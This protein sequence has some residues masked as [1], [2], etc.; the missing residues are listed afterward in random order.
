MVKG[1][2][3]L[4]QLTRFETVIRT[5]GG[6]NETARLVGKSASHVCNWRRFR[7]KIPAKYY[8]IIQEA[9]ADQG[10]TPA[11][12]L[13]NFAKPVKPK[14]RKVYCDFSSGNVIIVDFRRR[15]VRIAA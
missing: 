10:F 5:L 11:T 15:K 12:H 14:Q 2:L 7:G 13:F 9:L 3:P 4:R 6:T 1:K 8:L